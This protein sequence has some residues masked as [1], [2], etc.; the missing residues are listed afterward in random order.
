[1]KYARILKLL[2]NK[3]IIVQ[4]YFLWRGIRRSR[5]VIIRRKRK[6][7]AFWL[8]LEREINEVRYRKVIMTQEEEMVDSKV[9]VTFLR[10]SVD[11]WYTR[12]C[13]RP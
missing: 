6:F 3:I 4:V 8:K 1:M 10:W 13:R 12:S 5:S 7:T 2:D 9:L 11:E